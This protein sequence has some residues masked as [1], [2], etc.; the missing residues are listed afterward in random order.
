M[1]FIPQI[2][3][4]RCKREYS[5]LRGRCPH[6]G[7]RKAKQSE[8]TPVT[9]TAA[10]QGSRANARVNSNA[11]WQMI[12]GLVLVAAVIISVIAIVLVS[13]GEKAVKA[14]PTPDPSMVTATPAPT[15]TAT[16]TPSPTPSITSITIAYANQATTGFT[17]RVG[18][19]DV[20]LTAT[21]YPLT[22]DAVVIWSSTDES[23][24]TVSQD[25]VVSAVGSGV[26]HVMAECG[27]VR[28]ECKVVVP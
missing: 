25:G 19:A 20:P 1:G 6:C 11:Q 2:T 13:T 7:T 26:A 4:R 18:D 15:P 21:V 12:F 14:D 22:E 9:T 27:G 16:P 17:A 23:V 3:C 5:A 24:A 28:A 8:R 10:S